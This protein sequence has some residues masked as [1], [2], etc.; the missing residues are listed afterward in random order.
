[1]LRAILFFKENGIFIGLSA[2]SE[3]MLRLF[4]SRMIANKLGVR[5][6]HIGPRPYLRGLAFISIGENFSAGDGLWLEAVTHY[7]DQCFRP[8]LVIGNHVHLIGSKVFIG[9]HNHGSF[10]P[11]CDHPSVPPALRNLERGRSIIIER[12]VWL[13]DGVVVCPDVTMGYGSVAGANAVVT[14]DVAPLTMVA[15]APAKV[16][17]RY[18][19]VAGCW[20][21]V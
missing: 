6:L 4:R 12:N 21:R 5:K 13:G 19:N 2:L 1:L 16:I 18:D 7:G 20:V 14:A 10:G 11:N 3:R 17:R 15:G 9:D 8:Q